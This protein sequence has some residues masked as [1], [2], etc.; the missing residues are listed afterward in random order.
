[1]AW[2]STMDPVFVFYPRN[3]CS[4][5][6]IALEVWDRSEQRW[7][8][9]P[10][11]PVIPVDSCQLEDA[12]VLLNEI[13]WRCLER[14]HSDW[15]EGWSVGVR[16]FESTVMQRCDVA[17][18]G[19]GFGETEIH[20][21]TPKTRRDHRGRGRKRGD[22]RKRLDRR[23]RGCGVRRCHR[24]RHIGCGIQRRRRDL[25][26]KRVERP[27]NPRTGARR[28]ALRTGA[29]RTQIRRFDSRPPRRGSRRNRQLSG[30]RRGQH[31]IDGRIGRTLC[32]PRTPAHG[33]RGCDRKNAEAD[34][35][36]RPRGPNELQ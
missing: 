7:A 25:T 32:A 6:Q 24:D 9:H 10:R 15:D 3:F 5:E 13:R 14:D 21:S 23:S 18:T 29:R 11:H 28:S 34:D 35:R 16:V 1:M 17:R 26:R 33:R 27:R 4:G 12:G 31:R 22:R 30:P 19:G 8:K 36:P 2:G 20:V